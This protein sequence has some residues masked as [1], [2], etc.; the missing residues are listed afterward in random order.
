MPFLRSHPYVI[1]S[2]GR[3]GLPEARE[4]EV[5]EVC[6]LHP[7]FRRLPPPLIVVGMHRSGTSLVSLLLG[8]VGVYMGPELAALLEEVD[9]RREGAALRLSGY[10][11]AGAFVRLN[12][13]LLYRAGASWDRAAPFLERRDQPAFRRSSLRWLRAAGW[14]LLPGMYLAGMPAGYRGAWGW[15]DPRN[16]LTLPY[17][18]TFFP[19]ARIVHVRRDPEAVAASL[20]RR[21]EVWSARRGPG[22]DPDR[23]FH[24]IR[25]CARPKAAL[26]AVGRRLGLL[27]P[28]RREEP[29]LD[30]DYCRTLIRQYEEECLRFRGAG[31][32]FLEVRYEDVLEDPAAVAAELAAFAG[33]PVTAARV[34]LAAA[35]VAG[36]PPA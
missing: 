25:A 13:L 28:R 1:V 6:V 11:E 19:S 8:A 15:K 32:A 33:V 9:F 12:E 24:L 3:S 14:V 22:T 7:G 2:G 21:A 5:A 31:A 26:A 36:M 35:L 4:P 34:E 27:P 10:G 18:L 20:R 23:V 17:W 30:P 29:C 16:S